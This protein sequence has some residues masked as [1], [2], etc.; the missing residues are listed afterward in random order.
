M[1]R[2]TWTANPLLLGLLLLALGAPRAVA[3]ADEPQAAAA[4]EQSSP[5]M[6]PEVKLLGD[7]ESLEEPSEPW[8]KPDPDYT[9]EPYDAQAQLDIYGAKHMNK[10][11]NPPIT[12]G[13]R[14]YDR[15]AYAPRPTWLGVKNPINSHLMAYGDLR[16]G[17]AYYDNGVA[18]SSGKTEQSV[19]AT[20][21]NLDMDLAITATERIHA[22]VRPFDSN[23][24][25]TRYQIS[26][27]AKDDE[28]VDE[29][30]FALDTLFFEGDMGAMLQG[31]TGRTNSIDLPIALGRVP[32][33]T[34]NGIW[35]DDAFN[36]LAMGITAKNSPSLDI[37]NMDLTFF[38]GFK[39]V[40][41]AAVPNSNDDAKVFGL[42]GF[43]D[44][45]KGYTELGY[46]YIDADDSDLSYHNVTAAF[47]KRYRGRL[48]N[49]VRV[50]GNFGQSAATKTADGVLVLV[51]NSLI[52]RRPVNAVPSPANLVPYFNFFAG[53]D[54]PQPL[55]RA[56]DSGGVLK[57][58]GINF[59]SDGL[60]GYPT[61]DASGQESY[62]GAVG[63]EYLFS[64]ERQIVLEGAVVERMSDSTLGSQYALGARYQHKISNA[65]ILRLDAMH[66]WR[67]G[68]KNVYGARVE[69][70]RKL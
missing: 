11:A 25:F 52:P 24:S 30:D 58:T 55:A 6:S 4:G 17:A 41:T 14:L 26:G 27:G 57:N 69:I 62:G 7:L 18:S 2:K 29:F 12:L 51:E 67:E 48:A 31:W 22:F 61:L 34:Q 43:A 49:S 9:E 21:L 37:S 53:F 32:L 66:G 19:I 8:F 44:L 5:E 40:T 46:G 42:A 60:T 54:T 70:R 16:V 68:L 35:L 10:T 39:Q 13:R 56:A 1:N 64:L 33:F 3:A 20:R 28:F 63:V 36:G 50:I 59:E 23:G 38:A 45:R 65:W 47:T 15:G